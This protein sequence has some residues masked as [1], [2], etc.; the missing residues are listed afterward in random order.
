[1]VKVSKNNFL[2]A[3]VLRLHFICDLN[4]EIGA[5]ALL[6]MGRNEMV[7]SDKSAS[8]IFCLRILEASK[9]DLHDRDKVLLQRV[10]VVMLMGL[11]EVEPLWQLTY[12]GKL[13]TTDS[14]KSK[15]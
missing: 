3:H 10:S 6:I 14:N 9:N 1:M 2:G 11:K 8:E 7:E 12:G 5:V 13:A 4:E 15:P